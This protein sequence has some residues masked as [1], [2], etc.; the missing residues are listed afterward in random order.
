VAGHRALQLSAPL[1][2]AAAL[3]VACALSNLWLLW[4]TRS[5]P[6]SRLFTVAGF[7]LCAD[8]LF[9]SWLLWRSGGVLNPASIYYLVQIVVSALVLGRAWTWVVT[10]LSAGMYAALF[11]APPMELRA[12]QTMH[13]EIALH[14]RGMWLAFAGTALIIAALVVR[15][16]TAV[17]RRD[18]ALDAL[19]ERTARA[20]RVAG[21]AT[22]AAGAAHELSTPLSTIVV[23]AR[24]L[25]RSLSDGQGKP[26]WQHD[27]TLIRLEAGRCRQ[28]LDGMAAG[29]G[30]SI[31]EAPQPTRVSEIVSAAKAHVAAAE[32]DRVDADVPDDLRVVWPGHVVARALGNLLQN[33]VQ[34]S[35]AAR[36]ELRAKAGDGFVRVSVT[37]HGTGMSPEDL[38]RAGEPFF[39]TKPA[40]AGTGLGLFVARAS[41]EQLG[42][43]LVLD[44]TP[45][46]GTTATIVLPADVVRHRSEADD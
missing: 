10:G 21:L 15:L 35:A 30:G 31:G 41:V 27:A 32:R 17:E 42:G 44:S 37:D 22:L 16:A 14:I 11:L 13:P 45:G 33:A 1:V 8:V 12:A 36:V 28:I 7:L 4:R 23:A 5:Q 29:L 34:A 24:E 40:G 6:A 38:A 2:P 39:T 20:N 46:R 9:L 26:E 3:L 25:E 43:R 19:R 18:R